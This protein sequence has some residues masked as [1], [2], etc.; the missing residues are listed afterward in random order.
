MKE[1]NDLKL[2]HAIKILMVDQ[3]LTESSFV[4]YFN[5]LFSKSFCDAFAKNVMLN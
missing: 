5:C 1:F 4:L 2:F 3:Y